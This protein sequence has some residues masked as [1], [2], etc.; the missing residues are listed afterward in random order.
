ML[1]TAAS[2]TRARVAAPSVR[3]RRP[4]AALAVSAVH[5]TWSNGARMQHRPGGY[6]R[7]HEMTGAHRDLRRVA[8]RG[9]A[10]RRARHE[11]LGVRA[12]RHRPEFASERGVLPRGRALHHELLRPGGARARGVQHGP[13]SRRARFRHRRA[14]PPRPRC[15]EPARRHL[16]RDASG[17]GRDARP[18]GAR[19]RRPSAYFGTLVDGLRR[20]CRTPS[21]GSVTRWAAW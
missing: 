1:S 21:W 7:V 6:A 2:S 17:R 18:R 9:A 14:R 19:H 20:S 16:H 10:R 4:R 8:V 5:P 12:E 11:R 3:C 15:V 13:A